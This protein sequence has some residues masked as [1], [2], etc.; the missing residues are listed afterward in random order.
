MLFSIIT[1]SRN[2]GRYISDCLDSIYSQDH[3]EI[4]HI[5][6]DGLSVDNSAEVVGRYPSRFLQQK[7]T[8]PAQ[9]I[10]RGLELATGDIVCWLNADDA[11]AGPE[12][13]SSVA[14][15]FQ[16]HP[17]IDV[18]TGDG[19]YIEDNGRLLQPIRPLDISHMSLRW[20]R[21]IDN[22]LQPATFWRRNQIRLDET[23]H[24]T[25]DWTLWLDFYEASLNVCY[26][27]QYFALYRV[28]PGSL[29]QQ[30]PP[31]RRSEIYK[32]IAKRG[33]STVQ[34]WWCWL[35]WKIHVLDQALHTTVLRKAVK[36]INMALVH[37]TGGRMNCE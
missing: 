23:L 35:A 13:L 15:L 4:E 12:V 37:G 27:S 5:I 8:G 24:Y 18:I 36:V 30:D 25:F 9:A 21:R 33:N 6:M 14:K 1:P 22:F 7:D 31:L 2:Q 28:H 10:N 11:F 34:R 32:L 16:Q 20:L 19:Y 17:E 26:V 3:S 29:T